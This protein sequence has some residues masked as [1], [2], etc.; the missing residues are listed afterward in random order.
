MVL[1]SILKGKIEADLEVQYLLT[2][3]E[4]YVPLKKHRAKTRPFLA[5][6]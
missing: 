3:C 5:M 6:A 4:V 2:P 1:D